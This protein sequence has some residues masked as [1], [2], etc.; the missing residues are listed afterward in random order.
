MIKS[1]F[2]ILFIIPVLAFA[3]IDSVAHYYTFG[4]VNQDIA[5]DVKET[6]DGGYIIVGSTSSSGDGNTDIYLLKLDSLCDYQWSYALGGT[7]N[8]VGNAVCTSMDNGFVI[9]ST[10]NSYGN[11]YQACLMKRDSL[12]G[13]V[14]KKTYGGEDWDFVNDITQ[15]YDSGYVFC[16]ETYNN[17][18]GNSDVFIVKVNN[19]GDTV[20]TRTVGSTYADVGNSIIETSDSNIV[21]AGVQ[22][23]ITDSSQAFIVKLDKDGTILWEKVYGGLKYECLYDAIEISD[24]NYAFVGASNSLNVND[25]LDHYFLKTDKD[26]VFITQNNFV[27]T[28][29]EV[30]YSIKERS[31]GKFLASGYTETSGAGKKDVHVYLITTTGG[32]GSMGITF[33]HY[34]DDQVFSSLITNKERMVFVGETTSYG[35]GNK[36][37]FVIRLDTIYSTNYNNKFDVTELEDIAP[38]S[39]ETFHISPSHLFSLYPNPTSGSLNIEYNNVNIKDEVWL[40]IIS[41][42][43]KLVKKV[44]LNEVRLTIDLS[45]LSRQLY[46]YKIKSN[47]ELQETG[48]LIIY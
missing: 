33:G 13:Y 36:D 17:T 14:W 45:G 21:V 47:T 26:G 2:T 8:D 24:G 23:T 38:I 20:W 12:G 35:I 22:T 10:T 28:A 18:N 29:D 19:L 27:S 41:T 39:D 1:L 7:N 5:K 25:A 40:E 43:G 31:D 42:N 44:E 48:K 9:A 15:T 37:A 34:E 6:N 32:W 30:T 46:F 4:S 11:S 3:Q 16:G